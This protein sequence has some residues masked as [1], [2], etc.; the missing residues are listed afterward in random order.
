LKLY[1]TYSKEFPGYADKFKLPR[2][3]PVHLLDYK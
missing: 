1:E 2:T 3:G